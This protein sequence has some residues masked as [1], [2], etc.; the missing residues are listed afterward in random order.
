MTC[1]AYFA[2]KNNLQMHQQKHQPRN[3]ECYG[4]YQ[5]FNTISGILFHLESG[6]CVSEV[7]EEEIDD[8]ARQCYQ[9]GKY[10]NTGF[11]RVKNG[12]TATIRLRTFLH[13]INM[14]R[15]SCSV[16]LPLVG[17]VV[18]LNWHVS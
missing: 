4:C 18:W 16:R 5:C 15:M 7:T 3:M 12:L 17:M 2:N 1:G 14:L 13:S 10:I 8:L 11:S 9:S 6:N